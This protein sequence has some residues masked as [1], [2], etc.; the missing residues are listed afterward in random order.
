[1]PAIE[2]ILFDKDGT[3]VDFEATWG[4]TYLAAAERLF[5]GDAEAV[6]R[7]LRDGGMTADGSF[8]PGTLLAAG[9]YEEIAAD[10]AARLDGVDTGAALSIITPLFQEGAVAN[11]KPIVDIAALFADLA[12]LGFR[13]GVATN[14]SEVS[15]RKT[16][17]CL[18]AKVEFVVGCD[19][20]YGGK[21][22]PGMF[23]AF[24]AA[25]G[26]TPGTVAM[27]G[28]NVHD[29]EMGRRGGAGLL[30]G[31]LSGASG[32]ADLAP[33]ADHVVADVGYLADLLGPRT[34]P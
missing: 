2:A 27:V 29:L 10:W 22:D 4:P 18:A 21:P 12:S 32:E 15:A 1:M 30:I 25:L 13:I 24:C 19:S 34:E 33:H 5:G 28:D 31:V 14:D 26:L 9:S 23:N 3:L 16:M 11:A 20:G 17:E 6:S 8:A 7:A